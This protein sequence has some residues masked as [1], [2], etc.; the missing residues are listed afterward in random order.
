[1]MHPSITSSGWHKGDRKGCAACQVELAMGEHDAALAELAK[2]PRPDAL[3]YE[4]FPEA[5][6]KDW[7]GDRAAL[8]AF[9]ARAQAFIAAGGGAAGQAAA[10]RAA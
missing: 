7:E 10:E 8:E 9:I 5:W 6:R 4:A 2:I 1:M 3:G